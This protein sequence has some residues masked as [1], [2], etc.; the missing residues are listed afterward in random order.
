MLHKTKVTYQDAIQ[1]FYDESRKEKCGSF[2]VLG[3]IDND[4]SGCQEALNETVKFKGT[5]LYS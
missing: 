2:E 5:L 3:H 1:K 4:E